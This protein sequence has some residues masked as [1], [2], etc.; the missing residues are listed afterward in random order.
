MIKFVNPIFQLPV[1]KEEDRKQRIVTGYCFSRVRP[2]PV[3]KPKLILFSEELAQNLNLPKLSRE[4]WTEYLSGNKL[5]ENTIYTSHCYAGHQF[6][7]YVGQ[8]GDGRAISIGQIQTA[9]QQIYEL[10]LKGA[11]LTPFSRQADGRAV[12]RSSIR[13]FLCSEA[14]ASLGIPTTRALSCISSETMCRRDPLYSGQVIDE[15]CAI[16]CR[17]APS[18]FRFGSFEIFVNGSTNKGPSVGQENKL[19]PLMLDYIISYFYPE[20]PT[21]LTKLSQYS[22]FFDTLVK[23]SAQLVVRWQLVGFCHGVLNTDNM[24]ILGLT[25]D[26]GPFGF[27]EKYSRNYSPNLSDK[28]GRYSHKNQPTIVKWNLEKLAEAISY[29]LPQ[30][31]SQNILSKYDQYFDEFYTIQMRNKLG[32]NY[33]FNQDDK[34]LFENLFDIMEET[35]ADFTL[36]FRRLTE[37]QFIVNNTNINITYENA[38]NQILK[39]TYSWSEF[40]KIYQSR[41]DINNLEKLYQTIQNGETYETMFEY[42]QY[43]KYRNYTEATFNQHKTTIWT[44][45]LIQYS[46]RLFQ[47]LG[48]RNPKIYN[49]DRINLMNKHN[50]RFILRNSLAQHAIQL[51]EQGSYTYLNNLLDV[52]KRPYDDNVGSYESFKFDIPNTNSTNISLSCSS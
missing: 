35:G 15:P 19:L 43:T 8:L 33:T 1:D 28:Q 9:N 6:G 34:K 51:A 7:Y 29:C 38:L 37:V 26:Y 52:L 16:V 13:E 18:F 11:G 41:T 23:A 40:Q 32:L 17:V 24:S 39:T 2:T 4:Q 22:I 44:Q 25:I 48:D 14:M 20:I 49:Q 5:F 50:P 31:I 10:Q 3:L 36:T 30:F 46:K 27:M 12:L 42:K 47:D 45:W 21:S